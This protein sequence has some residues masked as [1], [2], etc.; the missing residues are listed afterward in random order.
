MVALVT[1]QHAPPLVIIIVERLS[2]CVAARARVIARESRFPRATCRRAPIPISVPS[3]KLSA[4]RTDIP[5]GAS[6]GTSL[7]TSARNPVIL[8]ERERESAPIVV[9]LKPRRFLDAILLRSASIRNNIVVIT[10]LVSRGDH[11]HPRDGR[12]V[13]NNFDARASNPRRRNAADDN[14]RKPFPPFPTYASTFS[15][16]DLS[17]KRLPVIVFWSCGPARVTLSPA[18]TYLCRYLNLPTRE[19]HRVACIAPSRFKIKLLHLS[20]IQWNSC[21][22]LSTN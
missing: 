4:F 2:P 1:A 6:A 19:F 18:C 9:P 17:K 14:R 16:I 20:E 10:C 15:N 8:R 12:S 11:V 3:R 5:A 22:L 21:R 7:A 13:I